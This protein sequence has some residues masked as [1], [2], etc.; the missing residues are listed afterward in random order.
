MKL[1]S[2]K[3]RTRSTR[4]KGPA[5]RLRVGGEIL[6]VIYGEGQEPLPVALNAKIFS[7][8]VQDAGSHALIEVDVSDSPDANG[9]TMLKAVDRHPIHGHILHVDFL[10]IDLSKRIQTVTPLALTGQPVGVV[11]GGV[12][13]HQLRELEIECLALDVPEKIEVEV[14][15]LEIGDSVHVS[16][17]VVPENITVLT[18]SARV[19]V[20]V[21]TPKVVDAGEEAVEGEE[22]ESADGDKDE[23]EKK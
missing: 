6:G 5:R 12:L 22:G 21:H 3:V 18:T 20:A 7:K 23:S 11:Q 13:E 15:Q 4:G 10:R 16:D 17:L 2:L 1:E 8:L 9:P 19:V 14:S